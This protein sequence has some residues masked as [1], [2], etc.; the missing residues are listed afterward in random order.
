M[1]YIDNKETKKLYWTINEVAKMVGVNATTLRYWEYKFPRLRTKVKGPS[2]VRQYTEADIEYIKKIYSLV[3][4][5]G[6]RADAARKVLE[7]TPKE[8]ET[9]SV[10]LEKLISVREQLVALKKQIAGME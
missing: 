6:F 8:V 2:L 1:A 3:K 9:S 10:V 7:A 4:V 5:R